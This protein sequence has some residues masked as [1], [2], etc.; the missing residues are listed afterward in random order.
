MYLS[1]LRPNN[2]SQKMLRVT[3]SIYLLVTCLITGLQFLSV[4]LKTQD[5]ISSEL[6][7]LEDTVHGSISTSMWQYNQTQLESLIAGLVKMPIIEGVDVFDKQGQKLISKRSYASD[8]VPMSI[9]ETKSKLNWQLN[10][11]NVFL[12]T[13][14]LYSSSEVV[15]DRVLFGFSLIAIIEFIK[16]SLL[17]W[18][19]IWAFDRYLA[20]PLKELMSQVDKVQLSENVSQ[21]INLSIVE[22]NELSQLQKHMNAMLAA[23]QSDRQKLLEDEQTK[24]NWLEEAVTK[25]TEELQVL[26]KKLENMA[27]TDSLTGVLNRGRFFETA[28]RL[29][30][31][32]QRQKSTT[33]LVLMDLDN[34]K[35]INDTFG[36]FSG[37]Q[38]L[39]HFTQTIQTFLRK[40]DLVGRLGGEEFGI[41]LNNTKIDD[42][43]MLA[44]KLRKAIA[45]ATLEIDG[46]TITYT[47][48]LG[49]ESSEPEEESIDDMFKRADVKL[50]S[51]KDKGRNRVEK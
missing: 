22:N 33:C 6:M 34:F 13:L 28:Q 1:F 5:S 10:G 3:F 16:I 32:G 4:Y 15:F 41:F 9:F 14:V 40:S 39:I 31:L 25:R 46:K 38:V 18:L 30:V 8:S 19:F 24:R 26:N 35:S 11:A 45:N 44:N 2:I 43:F 36:H 23:M 51:A 29:L 27:T 17:F 12:G 49:V 47:V 42:A 37:D 20:N 50:F 21:R 48:S 7:Q